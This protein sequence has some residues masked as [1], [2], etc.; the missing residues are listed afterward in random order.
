MIVS[1]LRD[2]EMNPDQLRMMG[3]RARQAAV[4]KYRKDKIIESYRTFLEELT[5]K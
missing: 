1:C 3:E 2:A 5:A 4:A